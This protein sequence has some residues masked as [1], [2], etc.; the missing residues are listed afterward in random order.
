MMTVKTAA[1]IV[2]VPESRIE[3]WCQFGILPYYRFA[4][5]REILIDPDE[6][7]GF[8]AAYRQQSKDGED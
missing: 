4:G 3:V 5:K 2:G 1:E 6:L 7:D 8:I